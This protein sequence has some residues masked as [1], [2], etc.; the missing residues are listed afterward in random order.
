VISGGAINITRSDDT[1]TLSNLTITNN[2]VSSASTSS[3]GGGINSVSSA[4]TLSNSL[5]AGN[6]DAGASHRI[7]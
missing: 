3:G 6:S 2:S 5:I 1:V 7:A 4:F